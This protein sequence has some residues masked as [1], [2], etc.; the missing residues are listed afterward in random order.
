MAVRLMAVRLMAVR[1]MAVRL[2]PVRLMPVRLMPVRL[3]AVSWLRL[4]PPQSQA[5]GAPWH[6]RVPAQQREHP[7][8]RQ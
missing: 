3:M 4:L 1:L 2:M 7:S 5:Q 6:C 8:M